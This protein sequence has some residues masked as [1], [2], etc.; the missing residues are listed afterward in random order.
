MFLPGATPFGLFDLDPQFQADADRLVDYTRRKLGDPIMLVHLSSSQIYAAFEEGV[1]EFSRITNEYQGKSVLATFLGASTGSLSGSENKYVSRSIELQKALAGPYGTE[2]R[3]NGMQ[4]L[5]SGSIMMHSQQQTYDLQALMSG[6]GQPGD[7]KWM[8]VKRVYYFSPISQ[9]RFFGT[10]STFNY[11]QQNFG[12]ESF[13][14][15]TVFYLLPLWEDVLR[16]MQMKLSNKIR[17]SNYSYELHNNVLILH[18]W[19]VESMPLW[20]EYTLA[21]DPTKPAGPYDTAWGGVANLSNIPFGLITYSKLNSMSQ[22]WCRR[23]SFALAKECEG[24]I[25]QKMQSIPIPNGDLNLNGS[26]LI[27]D[28]KQEQETLR[29]ELRTMFEETTYQ[30]LVAMEAKMATDIEETIKRVPLTIYVG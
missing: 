10:N 21:P 20:F 14:P 19:P 4:S 2:A 25:R 16:G 30:S 28:A 29:A 17:R 12:F 18:P 22:Q 24:Q 3:T 5:F 23:Y 1:A 13:T 8:Q 9:Y 6:T 7:G 27:S 15:E 26:E 11:L